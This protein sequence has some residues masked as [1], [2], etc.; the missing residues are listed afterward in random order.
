MAKPPITTPLAFNDGSP[1]VIVFD[2]T[3]LLHRS[4]HALAKTQMSRADGEPLWALHG[5]ALTYSKFILALKP[6]AIVSALDIVGGSP[7]RR[8]LAPEYKQ[9]RA[10]SDPALRSQLDAAPLLLSKAG[11]AATTVAGWEADDIL[12]SVA[13]AAS[14]RGWRCVVVTSDRDAYQLVDDRTLLIKPDG[15]VVDRDWLLGKLGVDGNGYLH[16]AA[17]RGENSDNLTGIPGIGDKTAAKLLQTFN[18]VDSALSDID[19]MRALIGVSATDR[20]VHHLALYKR[21]LDVATLRRDLPID[22]ALDVKPDPDQVRAAF[23]AAGLPVAGNKLADALNYII[24]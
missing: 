4:F 17:L 2:T 9:G 24:L 23:T 19:A 20:I 22:Y 16:L 11:L 5:T 10:Q 14:E 13:R 21:N 12:A 18:D 1:L 7:Y 3:N 15:V 8:N 6:T